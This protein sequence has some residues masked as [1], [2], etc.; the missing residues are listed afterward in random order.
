MKVRD[1]QRFL[2]HCGPIGNIYVIPDCH[3][4][5]P[6]FLECEYERLAR[7]IEKDPLAMLIFQGDILD[8]NRPSTRSIKKIAYSERQEE[9]EQEDER[10]ENWIENKILPKLKRI[11]KDPKR[12]LGM[13]DGDHY[14]MMSNGMTSTQMLC[15]RLKVPYLGDG[16][17]IL[18]FHWTYGKGNS[19]GGRAETAIHCQH[20]I[21]G[22]GRPGTGV[23][24]LEDTANAWDNV[25][26]FLRGHSH[27][28]FIFPI[29][30]YYLSHKLSEIRQRD[31]WLV[32]TP[33]FR[34]GFVVGKTDYAEKRNYSATAHKFPVIHLSCDK[35]RENHGNL[36]INITAELI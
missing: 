21:G 22:S 28:G 23:N 25:D 17:A 10:N 29:S 11:I 30:K 9:Y 24:K 12:C 36:R 7:I 2:P 8:S 3:F 31:I 14:M 34:T 20:G 35:L 27:K 5:S 4:G 13:M 18:R 15:A 26:I 19:H 32:N 33:S 1:I 16:Q 6:A